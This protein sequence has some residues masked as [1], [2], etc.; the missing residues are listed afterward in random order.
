MQLQKAPQSWTQSGQAALG[1]E[2]SPSS[3]SPTTLLS[4][5]YELLLRRF[6][7]CPWGGSRHTCR[8]NIHRPP[9]GKGVREG[10]RQLIG[11]E[12]WWLLPRGRGKLKKTALA[13][14]S[15]AVGS[16]SAA[17]EA[18]GKNGLTPGTNLGRRA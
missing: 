2:R 3:L 1:V 14:G 15:A 8:L 12:R 7:L 11:E 16:L 9:V 10:V 6:D 5:S 18:Q 13:P 4:I 17:W